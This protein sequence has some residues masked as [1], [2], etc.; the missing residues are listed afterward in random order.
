MEKFK[1]KLN[2]FFTKNLKTKT[3]ITTISFEVSPSVASQ[4]TS[5]YELNYHRYKISEDLIKDSGLTT[6]RHINEHNY[7]ELLGSS[8]V[9]TSWRSSKTPHSVRKSSMA[10]H[11]FACGCMC[12][13]EWLSSRAVSIES[14]V[15]MCLRERQS[16]TETKSSSFNCIYFFLYFECIVCYLLF[17]VF[18]WLC[19]I[20]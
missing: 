16:S 12:S 9:A 8:S 7:N 4:L 18:D 11:N 15:N 3:S 20:T 19:L 10:R 6:K 14:D 13:K 2:F 1:A 17:W 5:M